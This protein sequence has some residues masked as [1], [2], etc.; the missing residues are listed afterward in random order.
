[1]AGFMESCFK[2][3]QERYGEAEIIESKRAMLLFETTINGYHHFRIRPLPGPEMPMYLQEEDDNPYDQNAILVRIPSES[4]FPSMDK[5]KE[6]KE[7][8]NVSDV[9]DKVVGRLP[10]SV[11]AVVKAGMISG[12][13]THGFAFYSGDIIHG[14]QREGGGVKLR[15]VLAIFVRHSSVISIRSRLQEIGMD[16]ATVYAHM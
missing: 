5:S 9:L 2:Y 11:A 3:V 7:G 15:C 8:Q 12:D 6:T 4:F 16:V 14:G 1:M 13:M 10:R